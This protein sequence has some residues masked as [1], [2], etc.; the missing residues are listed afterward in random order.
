[1]A[2]L[3]Y[4]GISGVGLKIILL[5]MDPEYFAVQGMKIISSLHTA[6]PE[7]GNGHDNSVDNKKILL[8]D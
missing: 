3:L 6:Q 7:T 1:M 5:P 4:E 2:I 8:Q